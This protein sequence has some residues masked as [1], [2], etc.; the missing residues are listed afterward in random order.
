M[1]MAYMSQVIMGMLLHF[2][3]IFWGVYHGNYI[4]LYLCYP[5]VIKR[6]NTINE[7]GWWFFALPL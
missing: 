4:I 5:L 3:M 7:S 2:L 6:G 1:K